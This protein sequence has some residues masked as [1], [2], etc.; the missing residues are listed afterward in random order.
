MDVGIRERRRLRHGKTEAHTLVRPFFDMIERIITSMDTEA[1]DRCYELNR[2][3]WNERARIHEK[4]RFYDLAGLRKGRVS[5]LPI[6][7]AE[8]GN[9]SG[10]SLLHLQCHIGADTLSWAM[11]GA[12]VTGV[13]L[14]DDSIEIAQGLTRDLAINATYIRSNVYDLP[15]VLDEKFDVVFASYGALC[16]LHDIPRWRT[17]L[18]RRRTAISARSP[19]PISRTTSRVITS[20]HRVTQAM[21]NPQFTAIINGHT[22]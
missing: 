1:I 18:R 13:D 6:E 22:A 16:W 14:S 9:V 2:K 19:I 21:T 10:K 8:L 3:N 11:L 12:D 17:P 15:D 20:H 5:L 7:L 4:S